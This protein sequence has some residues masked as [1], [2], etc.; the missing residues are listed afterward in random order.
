MEPV[1]EVQNHPIPKVA[2]DKLT[3]VNIG[4][5]IVQASLAKNW[6]PDEEAPGHVRARTQWKD[7]IATIDI[8]YTHRDY[9]IHLVGSEN[10]KENEGEIHRE[11]NRRVR[12]L[13]DQI[14]AELYR[15][16]Y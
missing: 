5:A 14:E 16:S 13:E 12:A 11:Y 15:D 1:Y 6:R 8:F 10:L 3:D 7:H 9:S 4:D 2:R